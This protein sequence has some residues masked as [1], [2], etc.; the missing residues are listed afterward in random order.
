MEKL[1]ILPEI[2]LAKDMQSTQ[3]VTSTSGITSMANELAKENISTLMEIATKEL[4][5][6][7]KNMESVDSP[8]KIKAN[9]TVHPKSFRSMVKWNQTWLRHL[10]VRQQRLVFRMVDVR[11][12]T[13][14]RHIHLQ[15]NWSQTAWR[16]GLKSNRQRKMGL[17][18]W[19]LLRGQFQQQ[20]TKWRWSMALRKR[21]CGDWTVQASSD[22]QRRSR[23]QE[24]QHQARIPKQRWHI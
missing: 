8:P 2:T 19:N 16:M 3:M 23:R 14:K 13:W 22:S 21:K 1:A 17:H 24:S 5:K 7:I 10:R 4:S 6:T 11:Q 12:K 15:L 18:Q 9:T 20:Q